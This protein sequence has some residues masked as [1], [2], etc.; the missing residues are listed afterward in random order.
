MKINWYSFLFLLGLLSIS[1]PGCLKDKCSSTITYQQ[2]EPV[3]IANE[4]LH[5]PVTAEAPR[6]LKN[7]GKL[8]YANNLLYI[9]EKREGIHVFDNTNPSNPIPVAF[10][11]IPGNFDLSIRGNILYADQYLDLV[12]VDITDIHQ[13][14]VTYRKELA[15]SG[16]GADPEK[17]VL[18][19]YVPTQITETVSCESPN[20]GASYYINKEGDYFVDVLAADEANGSTNLPNGIGGSYARFC[21]NNNWLYTVDNTSLTAFDVSD[22][23]QPVASVTQTIGWDIESIFPF[24]DKLLLGS[25]T[26]VFIFSTSAPNVPSLLSQFIHVS[27]CDPVVCDGR[28]A[29]VT[30]HDGTT[31]NGTNNQLDVLDISNITS[32]NLVASYPMTKPYGLGLKGDYLY[33]C[34]D[35]LKIYDR[36]QPENLSLKN[37]ISGI[38]TYDAIALPGNSAPLLVIGPD[39]F[40]QYDIS[41]PIAPVQLSTIPVV[42]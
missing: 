32:A 9:N 42:K 16:L 35:G 20:Y 6:A 25:N 26:G 21:L 14:V 15:F 3:Y 7:P 37:H 10:L 17:G 18:V 29:F 28:Y 33:L 19:E 24:E 4:N 5:Q 2:W 36:T 31:C 23:A 22:A 39:G 34:D 30:I 13:P 12:A 40:V 1:L 38:K 41:N 27:G 8:Y 11:N